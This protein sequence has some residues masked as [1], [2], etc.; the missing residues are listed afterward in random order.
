ME[1]KRIDPDYREKP[2]EDKGALA[3]GV[4]IV[5]PTLTPTEWLEMTKERDNERKNKSN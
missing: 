2:P 3:G 5:P 4:L 1:L